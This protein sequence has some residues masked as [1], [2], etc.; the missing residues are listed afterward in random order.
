MDEKRWKYGKSYAKY[1]YTAKDIAEITNRAMGT[2]RNDV[3]HGKI[4]LTDLMS[5]VKY[6]NQYCEM[7]P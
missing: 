3:S 6:I 7:I 2:I 4:D 5:V 1:C